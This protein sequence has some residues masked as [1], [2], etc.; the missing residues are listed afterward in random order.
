MRGNRNHLKNSCNMF[1]FLFVYCMFRIPKN[2]IV[3]ACKVFLF[4]VFTG[5]DTVKSERMNSILLEGQDL[6]LVPLCP[7]MR[8]NTSLAMCLEALGET[9]EVLKW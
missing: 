8:G 7:E 4:L 9:V 3:S 6:F 1:A 2:L 5:T